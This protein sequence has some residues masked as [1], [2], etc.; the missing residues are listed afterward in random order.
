MYTCRMLSI[1]AAIRLVVT[2]LC[3]LGSSPLNAQAFRT[4]PSRSWPVD[5]V[6]A[7]FEAETRAR[8]MPSPASDL[9]LA[10]LDL[11]AS[12]STRKDSL[13]DGLERMALTSGDERVRQFAT[14][15][16]AFAGQGERLAPPRGGVLT[17]LLRIYRAD[18]PPLVRLTITN[19][20]P[21]LT[22]RREATAFL[23][24][25][26]AEPDTSGGRGLHGHHS[27]GDRRIE[28]LARLAE[29]GEEGRAVLQAMHRSGEARSPQA[30]TILEHMARRGFPASDAARRQP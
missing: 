16:I 6:L 27:P 29:M 25:I 22:E 3:V 10:I 26:A 1:S 9:V 17:R 30:R 7:R 5:T 20:L 12:Y 19:R 8:A 13:L 11:P 24:T 2:G 28:A 18:S 21:L 23:R 14:S 4:D 15:C